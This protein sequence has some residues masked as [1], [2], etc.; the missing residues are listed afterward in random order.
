AVLIAL[1]LYKSIVSG[2]HPQPVIAP[3]KLPPAIEAV[4]LWLLLRAFASGC[5]A[6]TGV[7]AVSN[8]VGAFRE[9]AVKHAHR[10][11]TCIVVILAVLLAGVAYLARAFGI[12]A[13][14]QTQP[15]YQSVMSQLA[16]AVAGHSWLYFVAMM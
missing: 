16:G 15:G 4:S 7:E 11:L 3:P 8:G 6:M 12:G 2:G 5:T 9:P 14:D 1:G 13:M 10:T